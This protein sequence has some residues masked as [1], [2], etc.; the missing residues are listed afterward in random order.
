MRRLLARRW[1]VLLIAPALAAANCN[2]LSPD[3]PATQSWIVSDQDFLLSAQP[4]TPITILKGGAISQDGGSWY[5]FGTPTCKFFMPL[6][7]NWNGTIVRITSTGG[8]CG[9]G[10][11]LTLE[12]TANGKYGKADHMTGTYRITYSGGWTGGQSGAWIAFPAR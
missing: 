2:L 6:S 1:I 4:Q 11:I 12:G 5:D 3:E 9:V 10:Y 7:G 8:S